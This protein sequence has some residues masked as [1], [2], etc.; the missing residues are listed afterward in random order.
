MNEGQGRE[1]GN[2]RRLG[3]GECRLEGRGDGPRS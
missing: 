1:C 3:D 2:C